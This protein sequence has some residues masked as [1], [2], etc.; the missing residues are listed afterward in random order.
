MD[1]PLVLSTLIDPGE[2]DKEAHSMD[3]CTAYPLEFFEAAQRFARPKEVEKI[4]NTVGPRLNTEAQYEGFG[5]T[6]E[7]SSI[8]DGPLVSSYT[9]LETMEEKLKAQLSLARKIKAVDAGDVA[10]RVVT[11][12][13]LP[14]IIG[15]LKSF[16]GQEL[17]CTA[18]GA[19]YRRIPLRGRCYCGHA[20]TLT[21][22]E[23]SVKKYLEVT[24]RIMKEFGLPQYTVQRIELIEQSIESMFEGERRLMK[25]SEF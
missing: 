20:L 5:F 10:Y 2:I 21:V 18:C 7:A 19:K 14:D 24:K 6:H 9:R 13:F 3:T 8:N 11:R 22:H 25:L 16:S 12:H 4:M 23:A 17:R 15:N 1:A